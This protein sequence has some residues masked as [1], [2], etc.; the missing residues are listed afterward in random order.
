MAKK[1]ELR[2]VTLV[3]PS[4]KFDVQVNERRAAHFMAR[5]YSEAQPARAVRPPASGGLSKRN[6][7]VARAKELGVPAKGSNAELEAAIEEAEA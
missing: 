2:K 6:A 5:G 7:L 1:A 3:H 4:G